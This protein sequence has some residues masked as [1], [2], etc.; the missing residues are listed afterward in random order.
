[1]R[2][3]AFTEALET[4]GENVHPLLPA[5]NADAQICA[6]ACARRGEVSDLRAGHGLSSLTAS[7]LRKRRAGKR[8]LEACWI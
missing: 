6:I 7:V 1:M 3:A 8:E 4:R 5:V 2:L